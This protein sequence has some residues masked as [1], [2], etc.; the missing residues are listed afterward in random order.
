M[1]IYKEG[2]MLNILIYPGTIFGEI[3]DILR[4]PRTFTI[5]ARSQTT[6]TK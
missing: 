5:K 6:V 1:E 4:N 3:G 2:I